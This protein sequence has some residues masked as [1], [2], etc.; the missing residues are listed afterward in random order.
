MFHVEHIG[1]RN[2]IAAQYI[3][4]PNATCQPAM[5]PL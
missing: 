2:D 4:T 5:F 3:A 1:R